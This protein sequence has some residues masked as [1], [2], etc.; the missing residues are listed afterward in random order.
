M[1]LDGVVA[2]YG[3]RREGFDVDGSVALAGH[4]RTELLEELMAEPFFGQPP[5]RS[6]GRE[7]FGGKYVERLAAR[8]EALGLSPADLLATA[9][10]LTAR[11]A[12]ES[13]R[14]HCG[15]PDEVLLCGGGRHNRALRERLWE[16]L[17][18]AA[19]RDTDEEGLDGDAKEAIAF[20]LLGWLA[21]RGLPNHLPHTTGA[22]RRLVLG[23][24]VRG[25]IA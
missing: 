17:P 7:L 14:R 12:A 16:E 13:I 25:R 10:A 1:V 9:A 18:G 23:S 6:T 2:R 8:G 24:L 20:A 15:A 22:A 3:L 21:A 4:A 5:P 11:A 19:L